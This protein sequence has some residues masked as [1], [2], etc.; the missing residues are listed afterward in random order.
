MQVRVTA[1]IS[2]NGGG[3]AGKLASNVISFTATPFSPPPKVVPPASG[4]L[5][6]TGSATAGDWMGAGDPELVSQ[7]FTQVSA[8]LY[9]ITIKLTGGASYTFVPVYGNWD[10]KYSI[11]VKNDPNEIYG[12]DFQVG[13]EDILAPPA[14]AD[15]KIT[16][17]FQLGKFSVVKQ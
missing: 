2:V 10:N 17:N 1:S 3:A 5:Y 16:V 13:G 6:I 12:G 7:K 8:T 14:T 9:E 15:Y 4:T 11:K